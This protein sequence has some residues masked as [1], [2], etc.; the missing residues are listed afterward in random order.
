MT[1]NIIGAIDEDTYKT[2]VEF[3]HDAK[4]KDVV[5]AIHSGGGEDMD[6][7]AIYSALRYYK[8]GVTTIAIGQVQ[9]AA[10]L[11]YAAG[12]KRLSH[13][14]TWFMVDEDAGKLN[15]SVTEL[16]KEAA[17]LVRLEDHWAKIM[18]LQTGV[19]ARMWTEISNSTT[20]LDSVEAHEYGLVHQILKGKP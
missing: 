17:Q 10:V 14:D 12:D 16:R 19:P 8:G 1:L 11:I 7:L 3:L 6:S 18:E 13:K 2:V 5:I 4:G 15:G 20:Y 9:S